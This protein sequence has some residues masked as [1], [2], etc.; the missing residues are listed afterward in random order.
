MVFGSAVGIHDRKA[1]DITDQ[2]QPGHWGGEL[3]PS[4]VGDH[5]RAGISPRQAAALASGDSDDAALSHEPC[6]SATAGRDALSFQFAGDAL[7]P[8]GRMC[9]V[10]PYDQFGELLLVQFALVPEGLGAGPGVDV[11]SVGHQYPA[12]PLDTELTAQ[13]VDECEAQV[14]WSAV[15]QRLRGSAQDLVLL[16]KLT[17]LA[18][19]LS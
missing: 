6:Y 18:V 17:E 2:L 12:H 13:A 4:Q 15:N 19:M 1:A 10:D 5:G 7:G 8:V 9:A 16:A 11:A 14:R 3:A